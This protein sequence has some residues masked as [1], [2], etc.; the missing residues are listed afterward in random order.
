MPTTR[1]A[2]TGCALRALERGHIEAI[3]TQ[4]LQGGDLRWK[5]DVT[6]GVAAPIPGLLLPE[7]DARD[8]SIRLRP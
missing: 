7:K 2:G 4:I 3:E 8:W 5:Q 1:A 6:K